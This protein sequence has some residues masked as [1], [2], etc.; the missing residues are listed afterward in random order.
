MIFTLERRTRLLFLLA[1]HLLLWRHVLLCHSMQAHGQ[2]KRVLV[3]AGGVGLTRAIA[4]Q[5]P[6]SGALVGHQV[7]AQRTARQAY[8]HGH[9]AQRSPAPPR[10]LKAARGLRT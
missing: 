10:P 1:F 7:G 3:C 6:Q 9:A 8:A 4:L 2:H 5:P